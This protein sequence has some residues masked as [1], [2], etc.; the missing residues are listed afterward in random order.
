MF[1][2]RYY[3]LSI[4]AFLNKDEIFSILSNVHAF[5]TLSFVWEDKEPSGLP[6]LIVGRLQELEFFYSKE[7]KLQTM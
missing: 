1:W 5:T 4:C 2:V 7:R 3:T 6:E